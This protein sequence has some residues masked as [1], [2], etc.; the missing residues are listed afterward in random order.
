MAAVELSNG[1]SCP[2]RFGENIGPLLLLVS[3]MTDHNVFPSTEAL[4]SCW[5]PLPWEVVQYY[6]A[7]R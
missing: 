7:V 2:L 1:E 5:R 3:S 6:T 4:I